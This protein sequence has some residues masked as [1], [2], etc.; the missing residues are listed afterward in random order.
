MAQRLEVVITRSMFHFSLVQL[1]IS[2]C[3]S[4]ITFVCVLGNHQ[5]VAADSSK[6]KLGGR[7]M[8][9][10]QDRLKFSVNYN[11]T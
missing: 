4:F 1:A 11:F 7:V 10:C 5:E 9:L 6:N 8:N 2:Q 3:F